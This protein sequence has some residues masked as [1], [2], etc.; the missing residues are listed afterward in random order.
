[1]LVLRSLQCTHVCTATLRQLLRQ[2]F[3]TAVSDD[4]V[5]F[6]LKFRRPFA[7]GYKGSRPDQLEGGDKLDPHWQLAS[8]LERAE[9]EGPGSCY[10]TR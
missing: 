4:F 9:R 7:A 8:E 2:L 3:V 5:R 6:S 10:R 1:M